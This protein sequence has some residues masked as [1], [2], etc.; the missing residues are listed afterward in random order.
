MDLSR[1]LTFD[2]KERIVPWRAP[3][4]EKAVYTTDQTLRQ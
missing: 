4:Y 1:G 2:L 3:V